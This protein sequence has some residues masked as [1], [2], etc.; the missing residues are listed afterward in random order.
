MGAVFLTLGGEAK[1]EVERD[2]RAKRL[3]SLRWFSDIGIQYAGQSGK[4]DKKTTGR[5]KKKEVKKKTLRRRY[6]SKRE[7]EWRE[8]TLSTKAGK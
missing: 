7:T 1:G 4:R 6:T 5:E 3:W 2:E 8:H